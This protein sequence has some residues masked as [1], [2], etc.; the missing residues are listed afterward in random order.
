MGVNRQK[1]VIMSKP[2]GSKVEAGDLFQPELEGLLD[3]RQGL[4]KLAN[5]L[6][7]TEVVSWIEPL[8]SEVG[9]PGLP[10]RLLAGLLLLKH[11]ENLSDERVCEAWVQNPYYQYFCGERHFQWRLPCDPSEL[12]RFRQ[13]IGVS[14]VQRLLELSLSLHKDKVL[15]E[16]ELVADT[17]VQESAVGFPTDTRL[18]VDC[19]EALW[20]MGDEAGVFWR[21][22]YTRTVPKL[23]RV[24][25]TRSNRLVKDRRKARNKLKTIAGRLLR[26]F[27]RRCG[28]AWRVVHAEKLGLIKRVLSQKKHDKS[29]VYSLHDPGV[30]C[31]AKGK[32]HKKYEF[33]RKASIAILRDSGVVVSAVSFAE[34]LYDGDTLEDTLALAQ[35]HTGKTFESVLVDRG[36]RGQKRIGQTEVLLPGKVRKSDSYY[37]R[38]KQRKRYARRAAIEPVIGHLKFDHRLIRCFLKGAVGSAINLILAS[39]AWNL[40]LWLNALLCALIR[41]L[42]LLSPDIIQPLRIKTAA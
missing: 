3:Q 26:D 15:A 1:L 9:R 19:I 29:K 7:W 5:V 32:A 6:P 12:V 41:G 8:Y 13:R 2:K 18:W 17:T 4:Y 21:R 22:R 23:L 34:N 14:G 35:V 16:D 38:M 11:L 28:E 24:L 10:V 39:A 40:K 25:R 36:Y 20:R 30:L 27:Q 33:G 31:I 42:T 37:Q